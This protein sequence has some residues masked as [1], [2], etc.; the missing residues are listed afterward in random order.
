[1]CFCETNHKNHLLYH[2]LC[3]RPSLKDQLSNGKWLGQW[4]REML[5]LDNG[6]EQEEAIQ[7]IEVILLLDQ[8]AV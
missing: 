5:S 7:P 8:G 3:V 4:Q 1:M 6:W 2:K